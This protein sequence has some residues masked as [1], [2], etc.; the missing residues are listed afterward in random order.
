MPNGSNIR[1]IAKL[2]VGSGGMT[3]PSVEILIGS[4][5]ASFSKSKKA[6]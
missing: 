6:F 1:S 5:I 2:P 3:L 4:I